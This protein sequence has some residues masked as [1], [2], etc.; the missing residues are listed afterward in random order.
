MTIRAAAP[1]DIPAIRDIYNHAVE[2]SVA[3]FDLTR[4]TVKEQE[5]WFEG[6]DAMHPVLVA[7]IDGAVAGWAALGTWS[8]RRGYALTAEISL[9][10]DEGH[11][12]LGIGKELTREILR[13]G[14]EAGLHAVL[15]LVESGNEPSLHILQGSGFQEV[16]VMR[17]VGTKFGRM[18]D[19]VIMQLIYR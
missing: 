7:E 18:L 4:R 1:D 8:L 14:E 6:H 13:V 15:A 5:L 9:Y 11:R 12:G 16:G 3:T 2:H 10:I 19:V 17:E